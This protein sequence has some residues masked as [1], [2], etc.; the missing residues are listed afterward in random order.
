MKLEVDRAAFESALAIA[1]QCCGRDKALPQLGL[2]HL[3]SSGDTLYFYATDMDRGVRSQVIAEISGTF[4]LYV[5]GALLARVISKLRG[6]RL[7]LEVKGDKL[8]LKGGVTKLNTTVP[9]SYPKFHLCEE[10]DQY[11]VG[12]APSIFTEVGKALLLGTSEDENDTQK[13]YRNIV[14]IHAE[15][16]KAVCYS[17]DQRRVA[18]VE[19]PCS[20]TEPTTLLVPLGALRT[21][22][23]KAV[24]D[25]E[26]LRL[27][28]D[29][30]H[31][32][33][34][35]G[36][37]LYSFRKSAASFP[38]L[39]TYFK[40][41]KFDHATCTV[42]TE[43]FAESLDLAGTVVSQAVAQGARPAIFW[44]LQDN[45]IRITT[46]NIAGDVDEFVDTSVEGEPLTAVYNLT[47]ILPITNQS[48]AEELTLSF[49]K[50]DRIPGLDNYPLRISYEGSVKASFDIQSLTK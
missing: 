11:T 40:V 49:G 23:L 14:R 21:L 12:F 7:V 20:V 35:Y 9:S 25:G 5:E 45:G 13:A 26:Q 44:E 41:R 34:V 18:R 15:A 2:I 29:A 43:T 1:V 4:D 37:T 38:D 31:I 32:Y 46:S 48:G 22:F 27:A 33:A 50:D 36:T 10:A 3:E 39:D 16:D 19:G 17:S 47:Q 42:S 8:S 30:N 6:E 28:Q 24:K